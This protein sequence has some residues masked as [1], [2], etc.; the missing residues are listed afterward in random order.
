MSGYV[1]YKFQMQ[2]CTKCFTE[3]VEMELAVRI[4]S[5]L[6]TPTATV[7]L[8]DAPHATPPKGSFLKIK[9]IYSV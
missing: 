4:P 6:A 8:N 5:W 7:L 3:Q 2:I 1:H 9:R